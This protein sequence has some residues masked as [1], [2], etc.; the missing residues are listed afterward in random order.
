MWG[1]NAWL[2]PS[3]R[4]QH[5]MLEAGGRWLSHRGKGWGGKR[6]ASLTKTKRGERLVNRRSGE[7]GG[8][9]VGSR[10]FVSVFS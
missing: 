1:G 10:L 7:M 8:G 2:T 9:G 6:D 4:N 3:S 5:R